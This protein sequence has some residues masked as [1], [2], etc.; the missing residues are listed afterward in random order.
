MNRWFLKVIIP[1]FEAAVKQKR[2]REARMTQIKIYAVR[3]YTARA[4]E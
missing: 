4:K 1:Q 3:A 2:E